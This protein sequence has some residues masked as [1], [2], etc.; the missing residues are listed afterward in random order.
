[1]EEAYDVIEKAVKDKPFNGSSISWDYDLMKQ[2][3]W[4]P[5]IFTD[6][7]L[8]LL[9][10][11]LLSSTRFLRADLIGSRLGDI[12]LNKHKCTLDGQRNKNQFVSRNGNRFKVDCAGGDWRKTASPSKCY[13]HFAVQTNDSEP[14]ISGLGMN[15]QTVLSGTVNKWIRLARLPDESDAE[16]HI[17]LG[18]NSR[19]LAKYRS[20]LLVADS[21]NSGFVAFGCGGIS[22]TTNRVFVD[23]GSWTQTYNF[24]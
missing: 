11:R 10:R 1:M 18:K 9:V 15:G 22:Y 16:Y 14:A 12:A 24:P 19:T 7:T 2:G 4:T 8:A 3:D 20:H 13:D 5:A 17:R 21:H 6:G 23:A